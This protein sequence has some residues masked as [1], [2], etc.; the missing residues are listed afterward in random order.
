MYN[1]SHGYPYPPPPPRPQPQQYYNGDTS[2]DFPEDTYF[3]P[4]PPPSQPP[5]PAP[6][7]AYSPS[8]APAPA[9]SK[10]KRH[11]PR[12][13]RHGHSH[14]HSQSQPPPQSYYPPSAHAP[15]PVPQPPVRVV[16][17]LTLL[18]EDKRSGEEMLTEVRVPLR[19]ADPGDTGMW[20]DAQ[21]VSEELQ[22]GPSRIDG[23]AKVYTMRGRYKQ[24]FLRILD[25]G[26]HVCQPANLKVSPERTLEI[27]VEDVSV[28]VS[29]RLRLCT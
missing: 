5:Q 15:P 16:R 11:K 22:R 3:D 6:A 9:P 2:Y 10:E 20:A 17:V 7:Y 19:P 18:I 23:R 24:L 4:G 27:F 21:E 8:P 29:Y 25:D 1:A 26:R 28:E 14:D 12:S 13:H